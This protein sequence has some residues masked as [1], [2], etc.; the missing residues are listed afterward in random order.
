MKATLKGQ[1]I[2]GFLADL[3]LK[4]KARDRRQQ[5]LHEQ[6]SCRIHCDDQFALCVRATL[7]RQGNFQY[8]STPNDLKSSGAMMLQ[9]AYK[10]R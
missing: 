2:T 3:S 6:L 5:F 9:A 8:I 7:D 4:L 10:L 1:N